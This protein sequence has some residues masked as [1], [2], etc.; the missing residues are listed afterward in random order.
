MTPEEKQKLILKHE[1]EM[2]RMDHEYKM[3]K[4][5][6]EHQQKHKERQH[7]LDMMKLRRGWL[8]KLFG[9]N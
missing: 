1:L 7:K 4:M 3:K 5:E 9:C 8:G 2:M 6:I